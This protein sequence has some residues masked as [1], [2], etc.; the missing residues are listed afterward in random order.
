MLLVCSAATACSIGC[1]QHSSLLRLAS[2]KDPYFPERFQMTPDECVF[3]RDPS[4]DVQIAGRASYV[5]PDGARIEQIFHIHV[6]WTPRPGKT[7]DNPTSTNATIQYLVETP[8]GTVVY[9]GAGFAYARKKRF[10]HDLYISVESGRLAPSFHRGE[11]PDLLAQT[12]ITGE[13]VAREDAARTVE[14]RRDL[15][16]KTGRTP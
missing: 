7:F 5:G 3:R 15:S 10:R 13:L 8:G 11:A 2:Y 9:S 14:L 6:F 1:T 12:R 4:G 16:L